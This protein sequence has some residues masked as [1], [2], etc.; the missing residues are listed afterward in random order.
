MNERSDELEFEK[1]RMNEYLKV[2]KEKKESK[3]VKKLLEIEKKSQNQIQAVV[4]LYES[5]KF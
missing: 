1:K 4:N 2:K 3:E 5:N